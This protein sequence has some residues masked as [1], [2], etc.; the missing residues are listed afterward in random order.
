MTVEVVGEAT[1][2]G[3]TRAQPLAVGR[4]KVR[5]P[6]MAAADEGIVDVP[7]TVKSRAVL[8]AEGSAEAQVLRAVEEPDRGY[9]VER[10]ATGSR[11]EEA[12]DIED[13]VGR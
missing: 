7:P 3:D 8:E 10:E 1:I 4:S 6:A 9:P 11:G 5:L 13:D 2:S 12:C